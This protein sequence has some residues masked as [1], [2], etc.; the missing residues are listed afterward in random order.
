[1]AE[2]VKNKGKLTERYEK[3]K[4]TQLVSVDLPDGAHVDFSPGKHNEL[5]AKGAAGIPKEILSGYKG[6]VC[7]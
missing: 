1:M 6:G 5:Q 3:R 2:F 7:G 4:N